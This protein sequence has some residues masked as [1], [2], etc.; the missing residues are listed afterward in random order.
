MRE[1]H[2][3]GQAVPFP[4]TEI[5]NGVFPGVKNQTSYGL[6]SSRL[7]AE[8]SRTDR[9]FLFPTQQDQ[10]QFISLRISVAAERGLL[11]C[12]WALDPLLDTAAGCQWAVN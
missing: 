12:G 2:L 10:I 7:T 3:T 9:V 6:Q 8:G 5:Y 11:G 1:E 4:D